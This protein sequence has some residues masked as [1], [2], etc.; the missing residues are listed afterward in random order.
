MDGDFA[1]TT[2]GTTYWGERLGSK[3]A[4]LRLARQPRTAIADVD[5]G[6]VHLRGLVRAIG[7]PLE[8]PLSGRPCVLGRVLSCFE[9]REPQRF[10]QIPRGPHTTITQADVCFGGAFR[11][12]D[13]TG[14]AQIVI[15]ERDGVELFGTVRRAGAWGRGPDRE[16]LRRFEAA[17]RVDLT[18]SAPNAVFAEW[19]VELD[20][21]VSVIAAVLGHETSPDERDYRA[22]R[23]SPVLGVRGNKPILV[24][25]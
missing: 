21:E 17:H 6:I 8:A 18:G 7:V 2:F 13:D 11:L 20:T 23:R 4:S 16:R 9:T 5:A 22:L 10:G 14:T 12:E 1:T 25:T 24:L 3:L 19:V 15:G